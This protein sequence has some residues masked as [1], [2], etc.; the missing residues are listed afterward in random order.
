MMKYLLIEEKAW[1]EL[2]AKGS[3]AIDKIRLLERHFNL[4]D[5]GEWLDNTDVCLRLNI[6]KRTLQY[7]RDS[8]IIP[9]SFIGKKCYYKAADV[10][11]LLD[12]GQT[13]KKR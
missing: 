1:Q 5:N 4:T 3:R 8:G 9:Y 10:K 12:G 7:Y 13:N 11:A 2:L 6:S